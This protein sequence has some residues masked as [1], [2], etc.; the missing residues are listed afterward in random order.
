MG[1]EYNEKEVDLLIL[2]VDKNKNGT[3]TLNEF[4]AALKEN[5]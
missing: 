3:I 4:K 5:A 1:L 2:A